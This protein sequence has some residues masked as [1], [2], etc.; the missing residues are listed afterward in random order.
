VSDVERL[1]MEIAKEVERARALWP[2]INTPH[3]GIAVIREEYLE[4]EEEV[5]K[6]QT[7]YD[8]VAMR[9]EAVHVAAMGMR[10]ILDLLQGRE[11]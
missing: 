1:A 7:E 11:T 10:F 4:L 8:R 9:K 6:K 3:E 2:A 5:F